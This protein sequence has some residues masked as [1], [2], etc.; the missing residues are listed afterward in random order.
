MKPSKNCFDKCYTKFFFN[1]QRSPPIGC[2]SVLK[3]ELGLSEW[4][5]LCHR[6]W[7]RLHSTI[8]LTR[9][10]GRIDPIKTHYKI[11]MVSRKVLLPIKHQEFPSEHLSFPISSFFIGLSSPSPLP[12]TCV[13]YQNVRPFLPHSAMYLLEKTFFRGTTSLQNIPDIDLVRLF[14]NTVKVACRQSTPKSTPTRN[15]LEDHSTRRL[16]R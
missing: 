14:Y 15:T 5:C 12:V 8:P 11:L 4:V 9:V 7:S 2:K 1:S 13:I 16:V 3:L 6:D 10:F